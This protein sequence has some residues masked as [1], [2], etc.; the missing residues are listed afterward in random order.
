MTHSVAV[1]AASCSSVSNVPHMMGSKSPKLLHA[2]AAQQAR[3]LFANHQVGVGPAAP[4]APVTGV[5]YGMAY[6][7]T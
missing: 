7:P 3:V 5:A 4:G 1:C 6:T 2:W